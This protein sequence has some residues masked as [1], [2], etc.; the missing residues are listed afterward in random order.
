MID[1]SGILLDKK[2]RLSFSSCRSLE[3]APD[4]CFSSHL[5]FGGLT[6]L[7]GGGHFANQHPTSSDCQGKLIGLDLAAET[8]ILE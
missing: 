3:T 5:F 6:R 1:F 2:N 4:F 8:F 7:H